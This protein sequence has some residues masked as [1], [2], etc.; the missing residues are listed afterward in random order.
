MINGFSEETSP[1]TEQE[2]KL[3]PIFVRSFFAHIGKENAVTSSAIA[4]GLKK[5]GRGSV[6]GA[7]IRKIINYIRING[8]VPCLVSNSKGYYIS[9]DAAE[10]D[11]YIESLQD[12][13][14]AITAVAEALKGQKIQHV[15]YNQQK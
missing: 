13:C 7:R 1:L 10:I 6:S 15:M 8:L 3:I 5:N 9:N 14:F 2:K 4:E 11:A 12:R